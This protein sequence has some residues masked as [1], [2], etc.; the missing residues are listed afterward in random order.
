MSFLGPVVADRLG[1]PEVATW[2]HVAGNEVFDVHSLLVPADFD[3]AG[4]RSRSSWPPR[5][6]SPRTGSDR[7]RP[8]R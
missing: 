3:P 4:P 7:W 2:P 6:A 5:S 1:L 8:P